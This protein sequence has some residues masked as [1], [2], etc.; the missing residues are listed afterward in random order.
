VAYT[1]GTYDAGRR[2]LQESLAMKQAIGSKIRIAECL[3]VLG[4]NAYAQ[5][6]FAEAEARFQQELVLVRDLGYREPQSRSYAHLGMAVLAQKRLND[7]AELLAEA[8][9]IAEGCG[10]PGSI[11]R[12]HNQLGY[13][14]LTQGAPDTARQHWRT[15]IDVARRI[16]DRPQLLVT[17]D[18]LIGLA[19]LMVNVDNVERGTELLTLVHRVAT[20]DRRTATK[21][22][23]MLADLEGRLSPARFT[24]AHTRG[25]ALALDATVVAVLAEGAT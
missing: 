24:A 12:A 5:G 20:I 1:L 2:L 18:A 9:T 17:L 13:L 4:E 14:A 21:A 16:Q 23:Q 11:S 22:E 3:E 8:L 25:S 10:D 15:A 7:A 6:Q 19:T